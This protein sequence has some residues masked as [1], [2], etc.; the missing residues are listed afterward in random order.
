MNSVNW[1]KFG[2]TLPSGAGAILYFTYP[3]WYNHSAGKLSDALQTLAHT[4]SD[5]ESMREGANEGGDP[6]PNVKGRQGARSLRAI[7]GRARRARHPHP[8]WRRRVEG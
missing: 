6:A 7:A 3:T 8:S 5:C 1:G 4:P 2:V